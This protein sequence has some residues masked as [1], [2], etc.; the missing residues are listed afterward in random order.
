MVLSLILSIAAISLTSI[1]VGGGGLGY[2]VIMC[3]DPN[4]ANICSYVH[5]HGFPFVWIELESLTKYGSGEMV[6]LSISKILPLNLAGDT[7]F[8]SL[9]FVIL[10]SLKWQSPKNVQS[11]NSQ[12]T[13]KP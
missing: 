1:P 9:S 3:S 12:D 7:A 10:F 11:L 13:K 8:W 5:S 6:S 4:G 2:D